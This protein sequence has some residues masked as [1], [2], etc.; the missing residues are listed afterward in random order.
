MPK[1]SDSSRYHRKS[2]LIRALDDLRVF[3]GS[4]GLDDGTDADFGSF[5]Q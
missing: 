2:K 4:A 1:P 3:D 5:F